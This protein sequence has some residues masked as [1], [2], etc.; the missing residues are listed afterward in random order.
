MAVAEPDDGD[1]A[2]ESRY[3]LPSSSPSHAPSPRTNVTSV[4]AYVSSSGARRSRRSCGDHLRPADLGAHADLRRADRGT[5]L[6][7]DPALECAGVEQLARL[8]R[9]DHRHDDAP[10][11][12]PG[13]RRRRR[14]S[15][16][17]RARPRARPPSR[18]RS[19]SAALRASGATTGISPLLE[20]GDDRPRART[21]SDPRPC[22]ASEPA[23]R[24]SPISS[25]KSGSASVADRSAQRGV[26]VGHRFA[27][28]LER[29]SRV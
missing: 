12:Q 29:S 6:R 25:P 19:R 26:D 3:R 23:A 18:P 16:P 1:A 8:L 27:D 7:D 2:D 28:N 5:K 11:E 22:R 4:R 24:C 13:V 21:A 14:G 15:A 17:R 20:R 9:V 10:V